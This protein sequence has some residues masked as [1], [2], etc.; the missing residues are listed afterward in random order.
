MQSTTK[1]RGRAEQGSAGQGR[2]AHLPLCIFLYSDDTCPKQKQGNMG[3]RKYV[4]PLTLH[5]CMQPHARH[6]VACNS[7]MALQHVVHAGSHCSRM[8]LTTV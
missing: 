7:V 8:H 6:S 3:K 2:I 1:Y 4:P 5:V